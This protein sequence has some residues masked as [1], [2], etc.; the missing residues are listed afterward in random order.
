MV[1]IFSLSLFIPL[2]NVDMIQHHTFKPFYH[3]SYC[4][5]KDRVSIIIRYKLLLILTVFFSSIYQ[6]KAFSQYSQDFNSASWSDGWAGDVGNFTRTDNMLQLKT[7]GAGASYM[8]RSYTMPKDSIEI[9]FYMKMGFAP[10]SDNYA[11]MYLMLDNP[12]E[13]Q[14]NGYYL[15]AGENGGN[16]ALMLYKLENGVSK[17]MATGSLGA[18]A[19]DPADVWVQCKIYRDGYWDI[20]TNYADGS[21]LET[22]LA[23]SDAAL[24]IPN[25][26]YFGIFANYTSTRSDKFFYDDIVIRTIVRDS[27]APELVDFTAVNSTQLVLTFSEPVTEMSAKDV[28]NYTVE[29]GNIKPKSIQY[30]IS[31]PNKVTLFFDD[32][33]LKSGINYTLNVSGLKDNAGNSSKVQTKNFVL[34]VPPA[35]GDLVITEVLT[36]PY[37]G[38]DDFIEV[39]NNSNKFIELSGVIIRNSQKNENKTIASKTV[40]YPG[41]YIAITEDTAFLKTTYQPISGA[42]FLESDLPSFNVDGANISILTTV[43]NVSITLDSFDYTENLHYILLDDTKGVS[44][45]RISITAQSNDPN[46]WH[47]AAANA[48]FAT[49]GY[50]NS[51][52]RTNT[53]GDDDTFAPDVT[54]ISPNG[55]GYED[56]VTFNYNLGKAGYLATLKL[57]DPEGSFLGDIENNTLLGTEGFIKWDGAINNSDRLRSGIYIV[58]SR[59]FHPDGDVKEFKHAIVIVN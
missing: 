10:S 22:D 4:S 8:Y 36:D 55:D 51:N 44:L 53:T 56:F 54:S 47:S 26:A 50:K 31:T 29:P 24:F 12:V 59:L 39:Y 15:K 3:I 18:M 37:S 28:L 38:G 32:N 14:A 34:A 16:D 43:N 35:L 48:L 7:T 58:F 19:T 33:T 30:S 27:V 5:R 2:A 25:T 13:N 46:N 49:P 17:L 23:F 41:E 9:S 1:W 40:L 21:Y 57:Y 11:K 52:D 20:R 42:R 6:Y 45:E